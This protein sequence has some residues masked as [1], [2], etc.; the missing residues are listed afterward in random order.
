MTVSAFPQTVRARACDAA[1]ESGT[2]VAQTYEAAGG[3]LVL[4][5]PAVGTYF[6]P[7]TVSVQAVGATGVCWR[8]S[9]GSDYPQCSAPGTACAQGTFAAVT[10]DTALFA[11]GGS[12]FT[13]V[14]GTH[15]CVHAVARNTGSIRTHWF[16]ATSSA[17]AVYFPF[18]C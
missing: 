13:H 11:A 5:S 7:V 4:T 1:G 14:I 6:S 18:A 8:N 16:C 17:F 15:A 3:A 2:L 12:V 9:G 10:A